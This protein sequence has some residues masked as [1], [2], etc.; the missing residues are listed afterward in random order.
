MDNKLISLVIPVY[1]EEE[2]IPFLFRELCQSCQQLTNYQWELVIID[3][4]SRDETVAQVQT[5]SKEFPWPVRLIQLSRNFGHQAALTAGIS[6]A[7]GH[8]L[9]CLD[10]DLQDPPTLFPHLLEKF[11]SGYDVVYAVRRSRAEGI[12]LKAAFKLFYKIFQ[13]VSNIEIAMDSGDFGLISRRV[14]DHIV[15]M[16]ERDI[17]LRGLRSWV[18]FKQ[19]GVEYDR[20]QRLR[21]TTKYRL[22]QRFKVAGGAFFGFS[23][24][25]LRIATWAGGIVASLATLYFIYILIRRLMGYAQSP[26]WLSL[27]SVVLLIGGVQL[28]TIGILGEYIG[29]IYQQVQARPLYIID[30]NQRLNSKSADQKQE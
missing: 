24:L 10:A 29:R 22:A 5:L 20:P 23:H 3:D 9:I 7:Q 13:R 28:I 6:Q 8:A 14:A 21:G 27:T 11:E 16:P 30:K 2:V 4:G 1:N 25:P 17:L 12:L 18:G 26:G 19:I 15:S